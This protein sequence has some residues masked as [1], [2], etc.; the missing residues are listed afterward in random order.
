[1]HRAV[2]GALL[3]VAVIVMGGLP[4]LSAGVPSGPM[5][6]TVGMAEL[7]GTSTETNGL[8]PADI[9]EETTLVVGCA[10]M[11]G[12]LVYACLAVLTFL[13][14]SALVLSGVQRLMR[15]APAVRRAGQEHRRVEWASPPWSVLSLSQLSVL[16]V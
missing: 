16:R 7:T 13:A 14:A 6:G 11:C 15:D 5:S 2:V 4:A 10:A 12:D 3:V 1:M 8:P 9:A